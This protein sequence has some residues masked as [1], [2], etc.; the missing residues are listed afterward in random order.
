MM[1]WVFWI[2]V[3]VIGYVYLGYPWAMW[4]LARGRT[5]DPLPDATHWP[6]VSLIIAAYNEERAIADK[7]ANSLCLDYPP[8]KLEII[9]ASDGSTD[10]TDAIVSRF[11]PRGVRLM[12]VEGRQGK[13]AVQNAAAAAATGEILLFS[14]ANSLYEPAAVR[15]LVRHFAR[16]DVGCVEGKRADFAAATSGT[17]SHELTY[18]DWESRIKGWESRVLSCTG[19]TGSIYAVRRSVYVPLPAAMIS[20]LMEPLLVMSRHRKRQ[21][22]EPDALSREPVNADMR[23]EF[24][25]KVRIMTRCLNSLRMAPEVVNPVCTG[26]FAVQVISHRLLRWLAPAFALVALVSNLLLLAH[27]FY[28]VALAAPVAFAL[29]AAIGWLSDRMCVG[30][31]W[32]R[33][34]Y[35]F[36]VANAA[37]FV[38]LGN[39]L[40]GRNYVTWQTERA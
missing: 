28:R 38:A 3:A 22:F 5:N 21:V 35:Y 16:E 6:S 17:A 4:L 2:S 40:L 13:T 27:P 25:R 1:A 23:D 33:L 7:L 14:D 18:R 24:R 9:V 19:A 30:S 12:R 10:A 11:R 29:A 34:P 36:A 20:D 31:D 39:C 15:R 32:L 26:W 37:A 8:E